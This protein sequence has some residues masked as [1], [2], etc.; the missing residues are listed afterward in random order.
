MKQFGHADLFLPEAFCWV[1]VTSPQHEITSFSKINLRGEFL[2]ESLNDRQH[3]TR[4]MPSA[5]RRERS[6]KASIEG[7]L[8]TDYQVTHMLEQQG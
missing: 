1:G 8:D 6:Q 7:R 5:I 4:P 2:R 3:R